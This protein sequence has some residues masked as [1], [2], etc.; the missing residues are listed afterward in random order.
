MGRRQAVLSTPSSPYPNHLQVRNR[1]AYLSFAQGEIKQAAARLEQNVK[2]SPVKAP[3]WLKANSLLHLAR[4]HD[5][6]GQLDQASPLEAEWCLVC[7]PGRLPGSSG[8]GKRQSGRRDLE[9]ME[10]ETVSQVLSLATKD[11]REI[12]SRVGL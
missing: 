6:R 1:L 11:L 2:E 12:T 9:H 4:I 3:D 8:R 5:L 7:S 10:D